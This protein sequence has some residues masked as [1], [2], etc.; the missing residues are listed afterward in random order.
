MNFMKLRE[1]SKSHNSEI[2]E[3]LILAVVVHKESYRP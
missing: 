1:K 3:T 2:L